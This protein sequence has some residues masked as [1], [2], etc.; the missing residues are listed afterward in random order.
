MSDNVQLNYYFLS[1]LTYL[2]A[3]NPEAAVGDLIKEALTKA[4]HS[5]KK[6]KA[7]IQDEFEE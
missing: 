6:A 5:L 3:G 2:M 4:Q 1:A 7:E